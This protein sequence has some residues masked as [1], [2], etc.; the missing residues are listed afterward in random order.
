MNEAQKKNMEAYQISIDH[1]ISEVSKINSKI[2]NQDKQI[3]E[4]RGRVKE[5]E[6]SKTSEFIGKIG[7]GPTTHDDNH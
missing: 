1:L 3:F 2:M 5:M 6:D 7:L 4:L